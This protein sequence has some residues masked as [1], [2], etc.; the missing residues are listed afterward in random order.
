MREA[1]LEQTRE[2][3]RAR[4]APAPFKPGETY[5][6]ASGK[7]FD[8]REVASL[9]DAALDFWLTAGRFA[10]Q[11]ETRLARSLGLPH[12]LLANSGSSANLLAVSALTSPALGGRALK[13]GDEVLTIA[14]TFPTVVN[15]IL[16]NNLV[17][18][19]ADISLPT[20]NVDVEDLRRGLSPKTRAIFIPHTLGNP[21]D[22][23]AVKALADERDLWL[24]EDCCDALGAR[25]DGKPV[26]TF[27]DLGTFS[28]YP[29]HQITT[30]EGGALV[31]ANAR[32]KKAAESF[33][34]WGRDCWCAPGSDNTCGKRFDWKLGD[35]PHG[36]DHK[37]VY[38]HAGYN[39]KATDLQAAVGVVQLDRLEGF[40]AARSRNFDALR[41]GLRAFEDRLVLPEA[42]PGSKPSWF[43][44]PLSLR[45][46]AGVRREELVS[47]LEAAKIGTRPL[48]AG[49][50]TKQ[51]YFRGVSYRRTGA[52]ENTGRALR[53]AFWIGV[54]PG[55]TEDMV[56]YVLD[57]FAAFFRS[58]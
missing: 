42:T 5:I 22:L 18:V 17:P 50:I 23:R 58:R 8:Q 51:P 16:Q 28:F 36:Y 27:G 4:F 3:A 15:P 2:Y 57:R 48:F 35:L 39:L 41:A 12:A 32:L 53:D 43:G 26:S 34:D 6:P 9:V 25:Y 19:F 10:E 13:P 40:V 52:L 37:Y 14:A 20:Y 1:V 38:S 45:E 7:V 54:Y 44:L 55:I 56:V 47:F 24:I 21:F 11:F 49:D 29:A 46:G 31:T 30:G 33:R